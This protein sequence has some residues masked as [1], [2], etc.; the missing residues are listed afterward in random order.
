MKQRRTMLWFTLFLFSTAIVPGQTITTNGTGGG[1]WSS[2]STWSPSGVP[3][4]A[5]TITILAT[6]SVYFNAN[7]TITGT[8]KNLSGRLGF[9]T[10]KTTTFASGGTYEHGVNGRS[11]PRATWSTGSTCLINAVK[12]SAPSNGNQNFYNVTWD[13]IAQSGG[14][15]MG[16]TGNTVGGNIRVIRSNSQY[17]R[18]TASNNAGVSGKKVITINGNILIDSLTGF[19]TSTGSSGTDSMNII[20]KGGITSYGT[21]NVANGSG[22]S[23]NWYVGG[24]VKAM[25][26]A[27]T[28]N[29][30]LT[31]PDSFFFNGTSKQTFVR[32]SGAMTNIFFRVLKGAIVEMDTN[33]LGVS[34]NTT[35][36]LDSG[37][38]LATGHANGFAGNL[39]NNGATSLSTGANYTFNGSVA[40]VTGTVMPASVKN[41]TIN[42]SKGVTLS[43]ATTINGILLLSAGVFDN[44]IPFTLGAGGSVQFSG[45]SLKITSVEPSDASKIPQIFTVSQNYPNPFNPSTMITYGLP[46]RSY[47]TVK[48]FN[49]LGEEIAAIFSGTENAGTHS[50]KFDASNLS[51]G[52]YVYRVQ[53]GASVEARRMVLLK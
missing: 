26:G 32:G 22:A 27:F 48:V 31:K 7:V 9:D 47:V 25:A 52:V 19:F 11:I 34:T 38:T 29:S 24:D 18:L 17:M 5:G 45:G 46:A 36:T 10:T 35:F 30:T 15:N 2:A 49:L 6:D 33:S 21:F 3:T 43:Q 1:N 8:L 44:T 50:L 14:L 53:A 23:V 28:T 39:N 37:A 16:M 42:N 12:D 40:Q 13:C 4:G 51:S 20:L 41:L